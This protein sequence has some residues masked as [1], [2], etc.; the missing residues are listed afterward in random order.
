MAAAPALAS[1]KVTVLFMKVRDII[2]LLER[3]GWY[4]RQTRG[5]HLQDKHPVKSGR[6]TLL[7]HPNDDLPPGTLNS[8]L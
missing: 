1:P 4:L 3:D 7:G 6:V 8:V 5:S 2:K